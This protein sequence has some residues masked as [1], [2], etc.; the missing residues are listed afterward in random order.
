[1]DLEEAEEFEGGVWVIF[2]TEVDETVVN[3]LVAA[4]WLDDE[5]GGGL[6]A[7][8]VAPGLFSG[9]ECGGESEAEWAALGAMGLKGFC[10]GVQNFRAGEEVADYDVMLASAMTGEGLAGGAG[11]DGSPALCVQHGGLTVFCLWVCGKQAGEDGLGIF[12]AVE[13]F[14]ALFAYLGVGHG[15]AGDDADFCFCP[16]DDAADAEK[17]ALGGDAPLAFVEVC[18]D[19]GV[20]GDEWLIRAGWVGCLWW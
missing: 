8:A 3:T 13:C 16:W 11:V 7:A 14:E 4:V 20:G 18:G 15:L 17:L 1:V 5:E 6:A 12:S 2:H 10:E 19:D 9:V